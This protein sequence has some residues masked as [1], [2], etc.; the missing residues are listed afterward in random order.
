MPSRR[1]IEEGGLG[2]VGSRSRS[3]VKQQNPIGDPATRVATQRS[4]GQIM[5]LQRRQIL[6]VAKD[7]VVKVDK[8]IVGFGLRVTDWAE[9]SSVPKDAL[10]T[11]VCDMNFPFRAVGIG[12]RSRPPSGSA[13][14]GLAREASSLRSPD[15]YRIGPGGI[16]CCLSSRTPVGA[17]PDSEARLRRSAHAL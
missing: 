11:S 6:A 12:S 1:R 3:A 4:E 8:A 17:Q 5:Q 2:E 10:M 7:E 15:R 9:C 14:S 16:L 13:N